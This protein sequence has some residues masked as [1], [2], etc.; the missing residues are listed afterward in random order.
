[1]MKQKIKQYVIL[2]IAAV[3]GGEGYLIMDELKKTRQVAEKGIEV[4][5]LV[6]DNQ[7]KLTKA[8][9]DTTKQFS[10]TRAECTKAGTK[11][12]E[13]YKQI[14]DVERKLDKVLKKLRL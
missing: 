3:L 2:I 14:Q 11:A 1:M 5:K 4:V 13:I 12:E 6:V 7:I 9:Q 10:K 8:A